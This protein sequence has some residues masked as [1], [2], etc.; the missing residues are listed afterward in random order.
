MRGC[1]LLHDFLGDTAAHSPE[2]IAL[3]CEGRRYTYRE[4]DERANALAHALLERG[5]RRGDRVVV[6]ADNSVET[7]ISFWAILKANAVAAIVHAQSKVEKLAYMLAD[8]GARALICDRAHEPMCAI[9][10]RS[11]PQLVTVI[12]AGLDEAG[13]ARLAH[14]PDL[15]SWDEVT[16]RRTKVPPARHCIET[17]LAALIYTSG[18]TGEPKGVMLTHRNMVA[19]AL[20][21]TE[22]LGIR[23]DDV[24]LCVLSLAFSYG[25][26]QM[27]TAFAHGARLVLQ[28]SFA[29]PAEVM[30]VAVEEK[31]TG[32]PGVPTMF[33]TLLSLETKFDLSGVR[34]VT[35]AGAA[36]PVK[37]VRELRKLFTNAKLFSMYGQTECKRCTYLPPEDLERKPASVGIAVPNTELW[38]VDEH[39]QRVGPNHVGELVIRGA[40]VMNGYWGKPELT[41]KKL[42]PGPL[43]GERVLYT[44]DLCR[45][46]E[47]GYLYF[48]GRMDD[49]IKSRGEKVPPSEVEATILS[50]QGVRE[51]AVIGVPDELLGAAVKAFVVLEPGVMIDKATILHHCRKHL[52]SFKVPSD[53]EVRPHLPKNN[54]G[55][56]QKS[57]LALPNSHQTETAHEQQ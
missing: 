1:F 47:D 3:V 20:S 19:A 54:N 32:F 48:V 12:A 40:T 15:I 34:Y 24:I 11:A 4:L 36:L 25:L 39:G 8:T 22:Y 13:R 51:A 17:D 50:M 55:K 53:V 28:R 44:G 52:E 6:F 57:E 9:A 14:V 27:I 37:Y 21:T 42:R 31:V 43:P 7:A 38:L 18:S 26:Y 16:E 45:L 56:V 29:F 5:V 49:V 46:D 35:N 41:A 33:A 23:R 2:A 10:V 30:R